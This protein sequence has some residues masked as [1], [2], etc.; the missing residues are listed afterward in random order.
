M[1]FGHGQ[2]E[3]KDD[4]ELHDDEVEQDSRGVISRISLVL[5]SISDDIEAKFGNAV[6]KKSAHRIANESLPN[7]EH[8]VNISSTRTFKLK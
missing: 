8:M 1:R 2:D 4:G 3:G 6:A 5:W 7:M